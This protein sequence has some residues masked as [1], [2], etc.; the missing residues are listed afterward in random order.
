MTQIYPNPCHGLA[1]VSFTLAEGHEVAFKVFNYLGKEVG[2]I[3]QQWYEKGDHTINY[4]QQEELTAG[5]Y[6]I[7]ILLDNKRASSKKLVVL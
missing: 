3:P 7:Q 2:C 5:I 4:H 1:V 6:F